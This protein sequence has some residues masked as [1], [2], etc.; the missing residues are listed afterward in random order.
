M[1]ITESESDS[2][3]VHQRHKPL[4]R[5]PLHCQLVLAC[6]Q[7]RSNVNLSRI[8]RLAGCSGV[9]RM[10]VEGH[11]KVDPKIA[12]D[13]AETLEFEHR[14]SLFPALQKAGQE[15]FQLVGLE[16]TTQSTFLFEHEFAPKT[17]LVMGHE[18]LGINAEILSILDTTVEIPVFGLPYSFNVATATSMAVYEY[19]RQF[20]QAPSTA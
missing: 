1:N 5:L 15:G 10:I 20:F 17:V 13:A 19:A 7:F 6:P 3:F 11:S 9:K 8:A 14:R 12:R 2:E 18:R 16:Q 4:S